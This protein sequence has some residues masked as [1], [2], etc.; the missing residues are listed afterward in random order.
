MHLLIGIVFLLLYAAL[1][2]YI[3]W[4]GWR[5]L[6]PKRSTALKMLYIAV[7]SVLAGAFLLGQWFE[8]IVLQ[9]VGAYWMALFSLLLLVLPLVQITVLLLRLTRL[10]R[11]RVEKASGVVA[12]LVV[13]GFLAYGTFNAYSPVVRTYEVHIDKPNPHAD[14]MT[15]AM[16]AD[17]HFGPLS[18]RDHAKRMVEEINAMRPDLVLFPGDILDDAIRPYVEQGIPDL[19]RG[20]V[21]PLGVYASLGNHDKYEGPAQDIVEAIERGGITVLYDEVAVV[22][23]ALAL[24]GRKDRSEA[25]RL[26]LAELTANVDRSMP[27]I[28]LEHQPYEL[29]VAERAGIDLMVSGH[30]HRGQVAPGHLITQRLYELDWGYLRK[31]TMHAIVTSGYGFWGPPIRIGTRSEIVRIDVTFGNESHS[32]DNRGGA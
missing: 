17:M 9:V 31:G 24:I 26:P 8:N 12:L 25:N 6:S 30:T 19:L 15:I 2:Y 3:G 18:G 7:L 32:S 11:H 29:D 27:S 21:A 20:I 16:A 10:P 28:L 4:S 14:A 13:A 23:D 22:G 1:V 5:W